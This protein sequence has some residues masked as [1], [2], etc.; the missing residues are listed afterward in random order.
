MANAS[1]DPVRRLLLVDDDANLL[2]SIERLLAET[3]EVHAAADAEQAAELLTRYEF[4]LI[5]C[6][7]DMP[8]R[9]G[10]WLLA[11]AQERRPGSRRVLMSG[12]D[13]PDLPLRRVSGVL[14]EFV[15]KPFS[16]ATLHDA[17]T[18]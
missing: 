4:E 10:L 11:L 16:P 12:G 17:L 3:Y 9:D 15:E 14:H 2:R 6:D 8:G 7:Y 1:A 13:P 18:D 5:L